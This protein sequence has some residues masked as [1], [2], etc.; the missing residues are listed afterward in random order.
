MPSEYSVNSLRAGT[1]VLS[2]MSLLSLLCLEG[3]GVGG[4]LATARAEKGS[5]WWVHGLEE[6]WTNQ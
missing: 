2:L 1:L 5:S 4:A 6:A 3:E